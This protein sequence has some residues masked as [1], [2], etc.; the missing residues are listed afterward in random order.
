[1]KYLIFIASIFAS[2]IASATHIVGGGFDLQWL[3]GNTYQLTLVVYRDCTSETD[4]NKNVYVGIYDKKTNVRKDS[5]GIPR[6]LVTKINPSFAQCVVAVPGC[7]EKA[8]YTRTITLSPTKYNNTAGYYLSWERC[9]RNHIIQNIQQPG[10]ASMAFYAEI[11]SPAVYL[12]STPR[13]VVN[14]FTVLCVD[15]LF[16]YDITYNDANGD[17]LV[18]D[19]ITPLNGT[20]SKNN[21]NDDQ[22]NNR[23]ILNPG[24][25]D[26]ITWLP[27]FSSTE[28]IKGDPALSINPQTGELTVK[29]SQAGVFVVG[30]RVTEYR[31]GIKIGLVHLELQFL[32][33]NCLTNSFPDVTMYQNGNAVKVDTMYVTIPNQLKFGISA[34]D[35]DSIDTVYVTHNLDSTDLQYFTSTESRSTSNATYNWTLQSYCGLENKAVKKFTL[36]VKDRGCPIPKTSQRSFYVKTLPMPTLPSTDVL[37]I[38]LQNNK[39]SIVYFGDSARYKPYFK[40]YNIYRAI[41]NNE[42]KLVDSIFDR[43]ANFY[44]DLNCP[45]YGTL[46]YRYLIKV[47]N[48]CGNEG[49]P[50]D[51]LGTFDQLKLL[52]D[53]QYMYN[54][55]V[56]NDEVYITWN[57]TKELDFARYFL[58]KGYRNQQPNEFVMEVD[59]IKQTDTVFLDKNVMVN[60]TS[61][62]YYLIMLDT[63]GN[64][65]PYGQIFCTTVIRGSSKYFEHSLNWQKFSYPDDGPISYDLNRYSPNSTNRYSIGIY[66]QPTISCVDNDF[67]IDDGRYIYEVDVLHTP[68]G[69][70]GKTE[71]STSNRIALDQK[72]YVFIPNAFSPNNDGVNDVWEIK[73][74]FIKDYTLKVYDRWGKIVFETTNKNNL[75][76]GKTPDGNYAANDAYV[77][78]LTYTGWRNE[79]GVLHGNVTILR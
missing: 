31:N 17:S 66:N 5:I 69:W 25:Y 78:V 7:S 13:L 35:A 56:K 74:V 19:L 27:G 1:M 58:W 39:T 48:E 2:L 45:D 41:N 3:T 22:F 75:W 54:V 10:D 59:F 68:V 70:N 46:N 29:P 62:C 32:V 44:K 63:C 28:Q 20:L 49:P 26:D 73:D 64:Y 67:N 36:T 53:K 16:N 43:N 65:G 40:C 42:F 30:I 52:P 23:P 12:N 77:Y 55:T 71:R 37:C 15:N 14:P 76:N 60:D 4:F 8:I 21:P 61:H 6:G 38:E 33:V 34:Y 79:V 11:P 57:Q 51:T 72:P 9:C 18:Y 50:S 47:A 24:P